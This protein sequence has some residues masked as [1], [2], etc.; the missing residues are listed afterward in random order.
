MMLKWENGVHYSVPLVGM[1]KIYIYEMSELATCQDPLRV[2][3]NLFSTQTH[4]KRMNLAE[5]NIFY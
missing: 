4:G 3:V 5:K 1:V 2:Q